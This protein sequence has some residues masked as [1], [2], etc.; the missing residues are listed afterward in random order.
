MVQIMHVL[1]KF[2]AIMQKFSRKEMA[3]IHRNF[4]NVFE[5]YLLR[6]IVAL[7]SQMTNESVTMSPFNNLSSPF[8]NNRLELWGSFSN[9]YFFFHSLPESSIPPKMEFLFSFFA[10]SWAFERYE[11]CVWKGWFVIFSFII[12]FFFL[13]FPPVS[14]SE[15]GIIVLTYIKGLC[16]WIREK[17]PCQ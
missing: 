4:R 14:L 7:P 9:N 17:P 16:L 3:I 5:S 8:H 15:G 6:F 1:N 11:H 12:C 13:S 10:C 2:C